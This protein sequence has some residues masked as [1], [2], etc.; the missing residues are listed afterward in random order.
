M[1][2]SVPQAV[3]EEGTIVAILLSGASSKGPERCEGKAAVGPGGRVV[4]R[5]EN[6]GLFPSNGRSQEGPFG[7]LKAPPG[8]HGFG[9]PSQSKPKG[10]LFVE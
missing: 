1:H 4:E 8:V 7:P 2:G 3:W 6:H 9:V 10:W 5:L